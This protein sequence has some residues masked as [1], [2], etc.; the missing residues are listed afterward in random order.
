[1]ALHRSVFRSSLLFGACAAAL[2]CLASGDGRAQGSDEPPH[3][4][5]FGAWIGGMFPPPSEVT[6]KTCL[7]Q[8]TVIFTRDVVLRAVLT[9]TTY[10]QRQVATVRAT[11][12]GFEFRFEAPLTPASTGGGLLGLGGAEPQGPQTVGFG[13]ESPDV[14]HVERRGENEIAFPGCED[15]PNPLVRCPSS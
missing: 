1:M 7:A 10:A 13:C 4:W 9:D 12:H 14:L 2:L 8:P 11:A 6:A 3:A 15:F 5:L